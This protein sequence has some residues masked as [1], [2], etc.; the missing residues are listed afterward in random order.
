MSL[1]F[2]DG[3]GAKRYLAEGGTET[4]I[5][6]RHGY[7]FPHFAVFEL[8]KNPDATEKLRDMY[9]RYLDVVAESGFAAMMGALD[10]RASPD[11]GKLL[12]YS[13]QGLADVQCQCIEFLREVAQPYQD[14]ISEIRISGI[15]GPRGDAY[16]LNKTITADEA[17]DYHS[18]QLQTLKALNVDVAWAA[19]IN[20]LPEAV[21]LSRAAAKVGIPVVVSFTLTSE[22]ILRSGPTLRQAVEATDA[23]AGDMKPMCYGLNCSHPLEFAPA[24][25]PGEW[26]KRVRN[27]RPNAAMMDKIALCKLNHLE[28]GDPVELGVQLGEL[29]RKYPHIDMWGGCCGTW[30][31]HLREIARNVGA[32]AV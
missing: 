14:Q 28:E 11:W 22:H 17:E 23:E 5:M 7:D 6:F 26:F 18:V 24:L 32:N 10:Y 16:S 30:E 2:T 8:L 19:T 25:E 3:T 12:G 4:E 31:K 20:N 29:A 15:V 27:I 13:A 1:D 21:G 9:R